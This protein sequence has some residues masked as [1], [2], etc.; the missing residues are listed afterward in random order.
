MKNKITNFNII[1]MKDNPD[2][3]SDFEDY[4]LNKK[5]EFLT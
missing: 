4:T 1:T 5:N 3:P 2:M